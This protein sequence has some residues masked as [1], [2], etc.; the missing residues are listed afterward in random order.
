MSTLLWLAVISCAQFGGLGEIDPATGIVRPGALPK[1]EQSKITSV[2]VYQGQALVIREVS[3]PEG[4]G[5]AE[6]VI[7]PLPAGVVDTSLFAEGSETVRVLSTRFRTRAVKQDTRAEVRE[8]EEQLKKLQDEAQRLQKEAAVQEQDLAYLQ[9]LEGFTGN[10]LNSLTEKGRL[11]SEA[12]ITLSRFVMTNREEKTKAASELRERTRTNTEATEFIRRQLNELSAGSA[13]TERDAVVVI[14]RLKREA[15]KFRLGYLVSGAG[16]LPQYRLRGGADNAP[17]RLEYLAAVSQVSGESWTDVEITLSNAKPSLDAAPP[18]FLPLKMAVAKVVDKSPTDDNSEQS[19][20]IL[21]ALNAPL[22]MAFPNETPLEDVVKYIKQNT[23]SATFK[24]GLPIYVDPIGLQEVEKTLTSPLTFDQEDLPIKTSLK[25]MLSQ[26]GMVYKV[27]DGLIVVTCPG[28]WDIPDALPSDA[29]RF[30]AGFGGMGMMMGSR[31]PGT[32]LEFGAPILNRD[33][34]RDQ[35]VELRIAEGKLEDQVEPEKDS[36]SIS[37]KIGG[38]LDIPSR[39]DPQLLEVTRIELPAEYHAKAVPVLT[40]RVYR[41][42]KLTNKSETVLL[43]GEASVYVGSDFV[44]RMKLPLVAAGEPFIAGFG[45]DPQV[46]VVRRLMKKSR[47]IQGGN[48]V[49][50]YEFRIGLRNYRSTPVKVQLWDRLP[51]P[52]GE[53]V[54]VNLVKTSNELSADPMYLRTSRMDNML[55]WDLDVPPGA[56]GEKTMYLTYEF[57]LEF[58]RDLPQPKFLSGDLKEGPIGGGA[59]AGGMGGMGGFRSVNPEPE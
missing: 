16:W 29:S 44:G 2:T 55:R 52:E 6:I 9:K 42:A 17:V 45:V 12:I 23:V 36:P 19:K 8:K 48:Q 56:I 14:N 33:A 35:A 49:L 34:A 18:E 13:R 37:F 7:T 47:V 41:L 59:M 43:P 5:T 57:R 28:D 1:A 15:S 54:L 51:K 20:A 50:T 25:M 46:Q 40:P 32:E 31:R 10:S 11:D 3:V 26:L 22:T 21:A 38:R 27:K 30:P 58:A 4:E 39:R 24:S 53:A